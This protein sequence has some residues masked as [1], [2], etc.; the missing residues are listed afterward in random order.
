MSLRE[1]A[2][3]T[4]TTGFKP[5]DGHRLVEIGCV[6]MI[7]R[8]PTG[9]TFHRYINPERD[10]PEAA[11]AVHGLSEEFLRDKPVFGEIASEFLAFVGQDR[12]VIH[13][14]EFDMRFI[15]A[16][17]TW[18]KKPNIPD[19]RVFC[20]LIEARKRFPGAPASLDALC[21]RFNID[22]SHRDLHGALLDA[23]LLAAMYLELMGGSQV[24]MQLESNNNT[25]SP[26]Q[27]A[28]TAS[29]TARPQ[30][31]FAIPTEETAAHEAFI[32]TLKNPLWKQQA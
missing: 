8:I 21:K 18:V 11:F 15:N 25:T 14:A 19:N 5:S 13:N 7:N 20:T 29:T 2:L 23:E 1:I 4:E 32:N 22:N 3:D 26:S 12:L 27:T 24:A 9:R 31:N 6:E 17:L 10:M 16:E 30:R 28:I